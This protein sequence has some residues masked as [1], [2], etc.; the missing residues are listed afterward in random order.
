MG[1]FPAT[2]PLTLT[3]AHSFPLTLNFR[4]C[5]HLTQLSVHSP[6]R[7]LPTSPPQF[8]HLAPSFGPSRR[9]HA[10]S[11]ISQIPVSIFVNVALSF[12]GFLAS[13]D[14]VPTSKNA[15][16][17]PSSPPSHCCVT[18]FWSCP[19]L[20]RPARWL[21]QYCPPRLLGLTVVR[22]HPLRP[23]TAPAVLAA[24][25]AAAAATARTLAPKS[26]PPGRDRAWRTATPR[27]NLFRPP[28]GHS[29]ISGH[30]AQRLQ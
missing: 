19:S 5:H 8:H 22:P 10:N 15:V 28:R 23:P 21:L 16:A 25:S 4:R 26:S 7:N 11:L 13:A 17:L 6:H 12:T 2:G 9:R 29:P 24:G 3:L 30:R 27:F 1:T 18:L 20:A 14:L